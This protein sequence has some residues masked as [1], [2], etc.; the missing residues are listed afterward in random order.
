[1][2]ENLRDKYQYFTEAETAKL[3]TAGY[4]KETTSLE[5]AIKDYVQNYLQT[6]QHLNRA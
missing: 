6:H 5:D 3:R 4:K 2:P 1:M